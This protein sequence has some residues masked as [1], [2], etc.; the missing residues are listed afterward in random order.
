MEQIKP[1]SDERLRQSCVY[2]GGISETRDHVPSRVLLD[3]PLPDNMP[4]VDACSACNVG[5]SDDEMYLACVVDVV[6]ASDANPDLVPRKRIARI[7][8][9]QPLL[10]ARLERARR[11]NDGVVA[12]DIEQERVR[13]VVLKLARGHAAF[14]LDER[15]RDEPIRIMVMPLASLDPEARDEFET[16]P[17][18]SL[19]PEVGSRSMQ[20]M[21]VVNFT[22]AARENQSQSVNRDVLLGPDWLEVQEGRYRYLAAV[23]DIGEVVVRIVLSEYLACEVTWN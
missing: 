11:V 12:F 7:L 19:F 13:N 8:R 5:F 15:K 3:E 1:F 16:P 6:R 20:R 18:V 21:S 17:V 14:D 22:L 9:E 4:V 23:L 2:C 10:L